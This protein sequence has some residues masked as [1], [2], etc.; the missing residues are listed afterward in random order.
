M[1]LLRCVDTYEMARIVEKKSSYI[2]TSE[3]GQ[4]EAL[5][6]PSPQNKEKRLIKKPRYFDD[7]NDN[8]DNSK[9]LNLDF[10]FC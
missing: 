4:F 1:S 3:E 2:S 5:S 8:F 6:Q 9:W 10:K 7:F